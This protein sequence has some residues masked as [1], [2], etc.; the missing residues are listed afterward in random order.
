VRG[1]RLVVAGGL[2]LVLLG[3]AT[4][5]WQLSTSVG[6]ASVPCDPAI[7]LTRIPFNELGAG[8]AVATRTPTAEVRRQEAACQDATLPLRLITW[9]VMTIGGLV[10]LAGW[11]VLREE[12]ASS[13]PAPGRGCA[14]E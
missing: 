2:V 7:D 13:P 10:A 5:T 4:G 1:V 8:P 3:F 9:S 6:G 14:R 12:S 11:T